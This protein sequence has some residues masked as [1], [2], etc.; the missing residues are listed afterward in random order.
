LQPTFSSI[1][2]QIFQVWCTSCHTGVG[3]VP[4][5][6][7]RLD[8]NVAYSELVNAQSV[9]RPSTVRVVPGNAD[10]SYLVHKLQGRSDIAGDRMPLGG[11]YL[12]QTDID[13]IRSWIA[14]GAA[15]N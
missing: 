6:G 15:N 5:G 9:G 2:T 4:E 11:P 13:V 7:L 3:R 12:S 1:R 10:A 8:A 14:Q